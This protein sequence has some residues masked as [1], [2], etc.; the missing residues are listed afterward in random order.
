MK[1]KLIHILFETDVTLI[2][3]CF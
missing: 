1:A 2:N 3:I